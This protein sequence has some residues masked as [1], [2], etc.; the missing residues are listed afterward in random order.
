MWLRLYVFKETCQLNFGGECVLTTGYL[1]NRTPSVLLDGKTP[2]EILFN[3]KPSY[4]HIRIFWCLC[5]VY[6]DQKPKDKFKEQ[7]KMCV[8]IGYPHGKKS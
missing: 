1:I 4:E 6:N 5:Y 3:A 7:S 2:Y 8:F